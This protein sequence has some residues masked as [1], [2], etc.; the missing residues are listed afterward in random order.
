MKGLMLNK[1]S[2]VGRNSY[3]NMIGDAFIKPSDR[4]EKL[5]ESYFKTYVQKQYSNKAPAQIISKA[6][7]LLRSKGSGVYYEPLWDDTLSIDN[8]SKRVADSE[9]GAMQA[10]ENAKNYRN[11][12][13]ND[14]SKTFHVGF[15]KSKATNEVDTSIASGIASNDLSKSGNDNRFK[16]ILDSLLTYQA[17]WSVAS[18]Y[19]AEINKRVTNSELVKR[20]IAK[21]DIPE[22][23]ALR[24]KVSVKELK[25]N[26]DEAIKSIEDAKKAEEEKQKAIAEANR[27][28]TGA[29]TP[30]EKA[31][32]QA[33]LDALLR[34]GSEGA[35]AI[36]RGTGLPKGA[37]YIGIG[38]V[39][40]IGAY[41][42]FRKKA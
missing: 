21:G 25:T 12:I 13:I 14:L 11:Q 4:A 23:K 20:A 31:A 40:A 27:K 39:V 28:L 15:S 36:S 6:K 29:T 19:T 5:N 26:I 16:S 17:Y 24:S 10:L 33:E 35:A 32:A 22:L 30:E 9:K 2:K 42:M 8:L 3:F 18:A 37:V 34:A 41:L 7:E 1:P 38:L